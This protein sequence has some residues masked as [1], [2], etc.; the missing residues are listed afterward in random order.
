MGNSAKAVFQNTPVNPKAVPTKLGLTTNGTEGITTE[1]QNPKHNPKITNGIV[2]LKHTESHILKTN[3][4]CVI[5]NI[6]DV[7]IIKRLLLPNY[8]KYI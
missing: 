8:Y 6:T 2:I 3:K 5:K 7:N 4:I 1:A